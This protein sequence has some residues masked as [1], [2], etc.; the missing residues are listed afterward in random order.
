MR[1]PVPKK[2]KGTYPEDAPPGT[3]SISVLSKWTG[4]FLFYMKM[5]HFHV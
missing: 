5:L 1:F 3:E 4:D 2:L